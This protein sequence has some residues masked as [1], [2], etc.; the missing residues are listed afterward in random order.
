MLDPQAIG[1]LVLL[2]V[3]AVYLYTERVNRK[4][5]YHRGILSRLW[6]GGS[7]EP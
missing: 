6:N 7:N 4:T 3:C 1:M 5:E 2:A